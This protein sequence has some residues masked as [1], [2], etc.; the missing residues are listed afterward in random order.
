[1]IFIE[2]Y[3]GYTVMNILFRVIE[4]IEFGTLNCVVR[5]ETNLPDLF[6]V[7]IRDVLVKVP[8]GVMNALY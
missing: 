7:F 2:N 8:C 4:G 1:M 5:E 6:Y 3:L